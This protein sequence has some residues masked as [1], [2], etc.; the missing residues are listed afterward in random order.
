M[1]FETTTASN[2]KLNSVPICNYNRSVLQAPC[3]HD[4]NVTLRISRQLLK[5]VKRNET[6]FLNKNMHILE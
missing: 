4:T 5:F 6:E 3:H 2:Y 1:M